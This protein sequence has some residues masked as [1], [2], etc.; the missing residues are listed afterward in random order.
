MEKTSSQVKDDR[1]IQQGQ[2]S[3]LNCSQENAF[4][5]EVLIESGN[6]SFKNGDLDQAMTYFEIALDKQIHETGENSLPICRILN[7]I[8]IVYRRL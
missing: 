4:H 3:S 5:V 2:T 7:N 1:E 8:G 6:I